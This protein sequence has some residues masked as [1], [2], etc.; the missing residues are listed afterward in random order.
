[1]EIYRDDHS[2]ISSLTS[3]CWQTKTRRDTRPQFVHSTSFNT[4]DLVPPRGYQVDFG[5]RCVV[6]KMYTDVCHRFFVSLGSRRATWH[7]YQ[8]C[9]CVARELKRKINLCPCILR[10]SCGRGYILAWDFWLR[11]ANCPD[12]SVWPCLFF[13]KRKPG[14]QKNA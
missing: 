4:R 6:L 11:T 14:F 3:L 8:G 7:R 1:L 2:L 13:M 5:G 9:D 10:W 12:R